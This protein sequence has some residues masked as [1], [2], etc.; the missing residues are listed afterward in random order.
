MRRWAR[1]ASSTGRLAGACA[2]A[3][4][5]RR[6]APGPRGD[7]WSVAGSGRMTA[8]YPGREAD[9]GIAPNGP[10]PLRSA[11]MRSVSRRL[12]ARADPTACVAPGRG[13]GRCRDDRVLP[14]A[15]RRS[16]GRLPRCSPWG[17]PSSSA[18]GWSCSGRGRASPGSCSRS[19]WPCTSLAT[20]STT[21][22]RPPATRD[23][24]SRTSRTSVRWRCSSW[25]PHGST[26]RGSASG[27]TP[28]SSTRGSWPPPSAWWPGSSSSRRPSAARPIPASA[29]VTAAYPVLDVAIIGIVARQL[30]AGLDRNPSS[31]LLAAGWRPSRWPTWPLPTA[32]LDGSYSTGDVIDVGWLVGYVGIAAAALHPAMARSPDPAPTKQRTRRDRPAR[33]HRG[34][35][36]PR[37]R[38]A[39]GDAPAVPRGGPRLV[40][41]RDAHR[42]ARGGAP[43][44]RPRALLAA[45]ARGGGPAAWSWPDRPTWTP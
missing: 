35:V 34:G 24:R 27:S 43:A 25:P 21:T 10:A 9:R 17:P 45:A 18:S 14:A 3:R 31:L 11:P 38:G 30:L 1:S 26:G 4:K 5:P 20:S 16:H 8:E 19:A 12:G 6:G 22:S 15:P 37:R 7:P 28:R 13:G 42:R 40:S 39:R 36:R 32:S 2:P 41:R 33:A 44:R 23:R 29:L